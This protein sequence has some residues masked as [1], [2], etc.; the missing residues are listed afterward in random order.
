MRR[1]W[2]LFLAF[3][4]LFLN[5]GS[6][7]ASDASQGL[8]LEQSIN[9]ALSH[10][11]TLRAASISIDQAKDNRQA[12]ADQVS[13]TPTGQATPEAE[14]AFNKLV[15]ADINW[16]ASKKDY[17]SKKDSV[18][19]SV[20]QYYYGI[21]Q[22]QAAVAS[23]EQAVYNAELQYRAAGLNY[24][25]GSGSKW[26]LQQA[27]ESKVAAESEL[28]AAQSSLSDSYTKFNQLLGLAPDERPRLSDQPAFQPLEITSLEAEVSRVLEESPAVW[29]AQQSIYQAQIALDIY[30]FSS[31]ESNTY[32]A[33]EKNVD[34]AQQNY[35]TTREQAAQT[36]RSMYNSIK[37]LEENH[38]A[39]LNKIEVAQTNL[40]YTEV[41]AAQGIATSLDLAEARYALAQA[42][43]NL[44]NNECQH[45]ILVEAFKTPWAYGG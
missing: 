44:L 12:A 43:Q 22:A 11:S 36:V 26:Q 7:F 38:T 39:L 17:Q 30:S 3:S 6:A 29:K 37:Q 23:A 34:I 18:Y 10:S 42:R 45:S 33:T 24:Q 27:E 32:D 13:Y 41:K 21:L 9:L 19:L 4:L 25:L 20:Y 40:S 14:T 35:T 16:Q 1:F 8:T 31:T 2:G 15:Q 5:T 28:A